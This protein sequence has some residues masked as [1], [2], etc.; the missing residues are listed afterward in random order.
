MTFTTR[1]TRCTI[2]SQGIKKLHEKGQH[3]KFL[4]NQ[5]L[6][7]IGIYR[8]KVIFK[9]VFTSYLIWPGPRIEICHLRSPVLYC[10]I[11]ALYLR[12]SSL[13]RQMRQL[14]SRTFFVIFSRLLFIIFNCAKM[15][16]VTFQVC[17]DG[18]ISYNL[19]Q[20]NMFESYPI[21][22]YLLK[23]LS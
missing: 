15:Y 23:L 13:M 20:H 2:G 10:Y 9:S 19:Q 14:L 16:A 17:D 1:R 7:H 4:S 3:F 8:Y 5:Y 6:L 21:F 18:Y 11:Q 12:L 22:V